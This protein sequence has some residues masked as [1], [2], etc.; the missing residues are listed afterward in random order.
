MNVV[1]EKY[2]VYGAVILG[3]LFGYPLMKAMNRKPAKDTGI[4]CA[5]FSAVSVLAVLLFAAFEKAIGGQGLRIGAVSTYGI[6]LFAPLML[7]V[8]YRTGRQRVFDSYA[9][10]VLPSLFL[11]RIRC[12]MNGCCGGTEIGST[13]MHWPVREAELVFYAVMLYVFLKAYRDHTVQAGTLFPILMMSYG[14][15]R[16]AEEFFREGSTLFHMAYLWSLIS[17]LAGYCIYIELCKQK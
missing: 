15:F 10:Y 8:L 7:C 12:M 14:A 16:F 2:S 17:L 11:Q 13:G 5:V 4:L 9:V 6:Y 3:I 1:F